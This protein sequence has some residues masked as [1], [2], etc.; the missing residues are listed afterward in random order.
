[1][2]DMTAG[3]VK[4]WVPCE[5]YDITGL[6]DWL[7]GMAAQGYALGEWPGFFFIGRVPFYED[8][9]AVR[10][11]YRLEPPK[12]LISGVELQERAA[13]YR[14]LGWS[15]VT[16]IGSLYAIY[17]CDDPDAPDLY[18]D[19]QSL[20]WAMKR[21]MGRQW[22]ALAV[23]LLW[24][25]LV[26]RDEWKQLFTA[27]AIISMNLVLNDLLIPLYILMAATAAGIVIEHILRLR[28]FRRMK[29]RLAQGEWPRVGRRRYPERWRFLGSAA[30][31]AAVLVLVVSIPA[32]G[33]LASDTLDGPEDWNFPHITL[34]E[35]VPAGADCS[36]ADARRGTFRSSLL[37]PEQYTVV[38]DGTAVLPDG[39]RQTAFFT[40]EYVRTR[41]PAL[42]GVVLQGKAEERR[43]AL[44]E[45]RAN[46]EENTPYIHDHT[47]AFDFVREDTPE[48]PGLDEAVR[49]TFQFSDEDSP[50]TFYAGR[51]GNQVVTLYCS[52][53][54][55]PEG[56]L[57]L[58]V[59]R[60]G[61]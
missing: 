1:M 22:L 3:T 39:T 45:Y 37:A 15:F 36:N 47:A 54:V 43:Q 29:K 44:E 38:Q 56:A 32:F 11:R 26:F 51:L 41:S 50:R 19:P 9:S 17:R 55:D 52:G 61:E 23:L 13:N 57:A 10:A 20:G 4:K 58:L 34:D 12:D 60:L 42:A 27:P 7:N 5:L 8:P 30:F 59:Q 2:A 40:L 35:A 16:K 33:L 21:L 49:F 14:E 28:F 46:W 31:F 25:A 53:A 24:L 18:T 6:E 48:V